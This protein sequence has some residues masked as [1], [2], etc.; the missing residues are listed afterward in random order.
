MLAQCPKWMRGQPKDYTDAGSERHVA[1]VQ[2]IEEGKPKPEVRVQK[3]ELGKI[4]W[5]AEYIR[6]RCRGSEHPLHLE[7]RMKLVDQDRNELMSGTPDAT[8][9]SLLFDL[10]WRKRD[11]SAQMAAY[12][13]MMFQEGD[14]PLVRAHILFADELAVEERTF[15]KDS[16]LSTVNRIVAKFRDPRAKHNPCYYCNW[17]GHQLTCPALI[18]RVSV[19]AAKII[20]E[21]DD[22]CLEQ[23]DA[24]RIHDPVEMGKALRLARQLKGWCDAVESAAKKL[25]LDCEKVPTGFK[26]QKRKGGQYITSVSDALDK[27]EMSSEQFLQACQVRFSNLIKVYAE[28]KGLSTTRAALDLSTKLGDIVQRKKPTYCLLPEKPEG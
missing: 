16:A 25:A 2:I 3:D 20:V 28:I 23:W 7:R 27:S 4:T 14:W 26:L 8:C 12:A 17:C 19:V 9:G 24:S 6:S 18:D 1:L 22:W 21:E 15:T 10:K 13:A 11:Y 5:A